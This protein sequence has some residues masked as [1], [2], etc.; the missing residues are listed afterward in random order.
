MRQRTVVVWPD[1]KKRRIPRSTLHRWIKL[2]QANGFDG[3]LP[4]VRKDLGQTHGPR[5]VIDYAIA[6]LLE[7]P[8]RSFAQLDIY[9]RQHFADYRDSLSTLRRHVCAHPAYPAIARLRSGKDRRLRD[10][11]EAAHPHECWQ[12]DG[13]GP[14]PVRLSSGNPLTVHVLTVLDDH[15]RAVLAAHAATAEDTAAAINAF[16]KAAARYGLPERMQFDRGSA[17]DSHTFRDGIARCGVHRNYVRARHPEAQGKIEAYHRSLQRWFI[18]ELQT[19]EVHGLGHLQ[20]LLEAT[21][22]LVYQ[23]HR[24]RGIGTTPELRLGGKLSPR[25]ITDAD[26]TRAF[27]G[28]VMARSDK[29]TGEVQLPNGRFRVPLAFAGQRILFRYDP[30]REVAMLVTRDRREIALEP[31]VT[32]PLPPPGPLAPARGN[33]RLQ[34]IL[35]DWRGTSRANAEPAFGLPEVFASLAAVLGRP[36]PQSE[37]D[38]REVQDFWSTHGPLQ[39]EPFTRA[40]QRAKDSLGAARPLAVLLADLARQIRGDQDDDLDTQAVLA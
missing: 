23:K 30:L 18:D 40:C 12:L 35:D 11:Y 6:L 2:Y 26:L 37:R 21:I 10:R 34:R 39:R 20:D 33:G 36:L 17:F 31:F 27:Y 8:N 3:L 13:K 38:A 14:F 22:A 7:Q 9:L 19:Q 4:H 5:D 16:T 25:R 32:K 15:S 28:S 24:H 29:K 1:G